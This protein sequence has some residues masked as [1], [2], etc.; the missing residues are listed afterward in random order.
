MCRGRCA[1]GGGGF[2]GRLDGICCEVCYV[3]CLCFY[4][5]FDGCMIVPCDGWTLVFGLWSP[6]QAQELKRLLDEARQER[7][8]GHSG[9]ERLEEGALLEVFKYFKH[10]NE[11]S[12]VA[13]AWCL[14]GSMLKIRRLHKLSLAS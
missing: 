7:K 13:P 14:F 1:V 4:V 2:L 8:G 3:S 5:L 9:F 11:T 6:H 10:T 12:F